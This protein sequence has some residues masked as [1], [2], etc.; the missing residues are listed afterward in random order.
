MVVAFA[1]LAAYEWASL[2]WPAAAGVRHHVL[3]VASVL[4]VALGAVAGPIA[5]LEALAVA[6]VAAYPVARAAGEVERGMMAFGVPYIALPGISLLWIREGSANGFVS[7]LYLLL[8]VWATD[9]GAYA[10]GRVIGGR[11]LVPRVSPKKTWAGLIG[12]IA[13]AA[14]VGGGA[15]LALRARA[16]GVVTAVAAGLAIVAQAGD[17]F[18]S[19]VKRRYDVKDS[20]RLIPGHG[21]LLDRADGLMAAAPVFAFVQFVAGAAEAWW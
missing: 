13:C 19:A 9:I 6:T 12:A 4:V 5:G 11:K 21:G 15:A 18:E 20:S 10:V 7:L 17:V 3:P 16:P 14:A 2:I 8:V 1:V